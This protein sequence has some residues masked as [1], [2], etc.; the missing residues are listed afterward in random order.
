MR[1]MGMVR[2]GDHH[3]PGARHPYDGQEERDRAQAAQC[4]DPGL[5]HWCAAR[6]AFM[7]AASKACAAMCDFHAR[8]VIHW[9]LLQ[10]GVLVYDWAQPNMRTAWE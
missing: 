5:H 1:V 4:G 10:V 9:A 6:N 8:I 7:R 3:M 2:A